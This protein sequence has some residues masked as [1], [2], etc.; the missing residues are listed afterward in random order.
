MRLSQVISNLLNNAAKYTPEGGAIL[1]SARREGGEVVITVS[2]NGVGIPADMLPRVFDLFTQVR[3]NLHRSHGGLGIGLALVKQLV[4][5]HGGA[6]VA[7]SPGPGKGSAFRV[8]LPAAES[9]P[10]SSGPVE[11]RSTPSPK[12][13]ALKVLVVDDNVDVAQTVGWMLETIGH[14]YRMV[15]EGKLAVEAAQD[16]RPDA[17]LLDIGMPGMDGFE[18][19]RALREQTL[20]DDTVIIAQTGWGQA[21]AHAAP[22]APGFDHHL[23]KPVK[24]ERLEK[25]LA[26]V[27][28][29]RRR[30]PVGA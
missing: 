7:E 30:D 24:L 18:V 4:E 23:V 14:D 12:T 21:Q 6:I 16:Y 2:D 27:S 3:D 1:L 17:I 11:P 8:R 22:G 19:C 13:N 29:A 25:L 15:H 9:A 20:F 26:D 10:A 28:S 5:M